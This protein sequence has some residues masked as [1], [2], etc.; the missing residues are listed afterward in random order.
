M[1]RCCRTLPVMMSPLE[2]L[3]VP[4]NPS[5]LLKPPPAARCRPEVNLLSDSTFSPKRS[6]EKAGTRTDSN[7]SGIFRV[8]RDR[9]EGETSPRLVLVQSGYCLT[10]PGTAL[11]FAEGKQLSPQHINQHLLAFNL[12]GGGAETSV[13]AD[14]TA[15]DASPVG[16][17]TP[18]RQEAAEAKSGVNHASKGLLLR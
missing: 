13:K 14:G 4:E 12:T 1:N 17:P 15:E 5:G 3:Q 6:G 16:V 10:P 7:K 11:M 2:T 9:S 18:C 8:F